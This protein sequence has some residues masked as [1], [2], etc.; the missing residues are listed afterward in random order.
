[1]AAAEQDGGQGP[2]LGLRLAS[3]VVFVPGILFLVEWNDWSLLVLSL[4]VVGRG[5]W[6]FYRLV[7]A[8]GHRPARHLGTALALGLCLYIFQFGAHRLDLVL[9]GAALACL[10]AALRNGTA[11]YLANALTGL[12]GVVYIGLLGSAPLLLVRA[13]GP[14]QRTEAGHL[15]ALVFVCIWLADSAAYAAGHLWGRKKLAPSISPGKT[16]VGGLAGMVGGLVPLFLHQLVPQLSVWQ[17]VGLLVL[18]AAGGQLGDLVESAL[19]RDAGVKDSPPLIPGHGGILDRFDSYF[20]AFP[21]VYLYVVAL[22]LL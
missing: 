18:A 13:A 3:A 11:N 5:S 9:S 16:V 22:D 20:F 8:A 7:A 2:Q 12:G 17:W 6:E 4:G 21:L 19:K 15:L 14:A 10:L 1:M